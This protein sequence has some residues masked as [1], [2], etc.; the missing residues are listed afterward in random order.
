MKKLAI[1]NFMLTALVILICLILLCT[2]L[3]VQFYRYSVSERMESMEKSGRAAS[4]YALVWLTEPYRVNEKEL[5]RWLSMEAQENN[6]RIMIVDA[7]G[8]VGLYADPLRSG[9]AGTIG[10]TVMDRIKLE[11][12]YKELGTLNGYFKNKL[13]TIGMPLYDNFGN[14]W[15][16]VFVST[17][18]EHLTSIFKEF[19][20]SVVFVAFFVMLVAFALTYFVSERLTKQL[21]GM[22]QAAKRYAMGRFDTR[23]IVRDD[24]PD[25]ITDLAASFNYMADSLQKLEQLRS[26]FVANVSHELKTP[27]TAIGGFV[28]GMLDGTIPPERQE[29]YL[30]IVQSEVQRLSRLISRLLQASRLQSGLTQ[31]NIRQIDLCEEVRT[32]VIGLEQHVTEKQIHVEVNL[33][34]EKIYVDA[35]E[36]AL[37]QVLTNLCDNGIK[38][39]VNNGLLSVTVTLRGDKALVSVY[40]TGPGIPESALPYVFDRFYKTDRSRGLDKQ[41]TGLGLYITKSIL[42]NMNQEIY[43]ESKEGEYV[44]FTFTLTLSKFQ[45]KPELKS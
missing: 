16:A 12:Q 4:L 34:R 9:T 14:L 21:A 7:S 27:L 26:E 30:A 43:A 6:A 25:E 24:A 42:Q 19:L 40:N 13:L 28:G 45:N 44:R 11:G 3:L 2:L 32:V 31:M 18:T 38:Y 37:R 17:P 20:E 8:D 35:D 15:G 41:S 1:R 29:H 22:A 36:D 33:P 39:G 23:V 5:I 10:K